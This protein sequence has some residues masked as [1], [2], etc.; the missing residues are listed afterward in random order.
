MHCIILAAGF[1]T[2]L[3]PLTHNFPKALLPIK[4]KA[5]IDYIIDDVIRQ[6][7]ITHVTIVTNDKFFSLFQKHVKNAF[8][9]REITVLNNGIMDESAKNGAIKD[10]SYAITKSAIAEDIL[11]LASDTFTSLKLQDLIRFYKQFKNITTAVF[12]GKDVERIRGKLGCAVVERG[13]LMR[14]EEKPQ[15]PPTTLMAVP[16]YII[17]Q[18][19][20]PLVATY[21][22][23]NNAD[24]PGNFIAWALT[25]T[26]VYAFNIGTGYYYDIG[27]E[28][29]YEKLK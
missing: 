18:S 24:A 6:K 15:T 4:G 22:D 26:S 10:L 25:Q 23:G 29:Q 21:L 5:V 27:T 8:P 2:R 16:F 14:F 9:E 3:Y 20:F 28:E 12:D 7:D 11:V 1:A 17:P 13:K 19:A